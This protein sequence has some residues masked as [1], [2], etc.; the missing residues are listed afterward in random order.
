[1][2]EAKREIEKYVMLATL[3]TQVNGL[4]KRV[5]KIESQCKKK[6]K[7]APLGERKSYRDKEVE[8]IEENLSTILLKLSEKDG[9]LDELKEDTEGIRRIIWSHTKVVQ[10]LEKLMEQELSH[11]QTHE[12][13]GGVKSSKEGQARAL[14]PGDKGKGKSPISDRVT[15]GSQTA[16]F[17]P[18]DDQPLLSRWNEI[19]DRSQ[20]DSARVPPTATPA[21]SVPA[22]APPFAPIPPVSPPPRHLNRLKGD[23][24]ALVPKSKKKADE[25]RPVKSVMVRGVEVGCNSDIINVVLERATRVQI[26][27]KDLNVPAQYWFGF[28]SS[29]IRPSQNE[30]ILWHAKAACLESILGKRRLNLGLIIEQEMGMR[31]KQKHTSLPFPILITE[32][33]KHAG[34]P[35]DAARDFDVTPSSSTDIRCIKAEYTRKEDDRRREYPVDKS[36][37][38]DIN[39]IAT[40]EFCLLRPS[41]T[42][43]PSSFS[44]APGT[45]SSSQQ[46]KITQ[47]M[48]LKMGHLAHSAD[49]RGTRLERDLLLMIEAAILAAL[50]PL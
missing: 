6:D 34:V 16:L 24:A 39:A 46:T 23:D 47:A 32:L 42:S 38:V 27:K 8:R 12:N 49:V 20:P 30:S 18:E 4:A 5:M 26:E 9:S 17:E 40:E 28:I 48:I 37:E 36:S 11:V 50:T 44:H 14:P 13:Q 15:T 43:S 2:A 21:N 35:R 19:G 31:A 29:S 41:G 3:R 7:C 25:F 1:M 10:Q 22:L 33:C 45:S